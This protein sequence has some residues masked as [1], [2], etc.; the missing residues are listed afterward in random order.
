MPKYCRSDNCQSPIV[1]E[2]RQMGAMVKVVSQ[3]KLGFDIIV[4]MYGTVVL[5]E[6]KNTKKDKL[7]INETTFANEWAGYVYR[8]ESSEKVRTIMAAKSAG[9]HL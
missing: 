2:L 5:F 3:H 7:T 6:L 4:G 1:K 9:E 8:A